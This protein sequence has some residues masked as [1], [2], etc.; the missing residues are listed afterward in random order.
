MLAELLSA[1]GGPLEWRSIRAAD[2]SAQWER[3]RD[4]VNWFRIEFAFDHRVV[5][6]CWYR[7]RALVQVLSALRDDWL[8]AYDPLSN[9]DGAAA[10]HRSLMLLEQRLRDFASRT[11]CTFDMHRAELI[12]GYP[13]DAGQWRAHVDADVALREHLETEARTVRGGETTREAADGS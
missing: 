13:D 2:A 6:P 7:H 4:W 8:V 10:W 5:P 9:R 1:S 12:P 11:G 3:L